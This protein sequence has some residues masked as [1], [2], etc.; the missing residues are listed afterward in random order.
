MIIFAVLSATTWININLIMMD[1]QLIEF[2]SR[3]ELLRL[4]VQRIVYIEADGNYSY[5]VTC[6]KLKGAV[7]MNLGQV[8]D[9][10]A[11]RLKERKSIF[12]R[13]GKK[14][15]VNLNYV[16]KINPLKKQL[17]LTDFNHFAF[18]L[19]ISREAL[20]ALKELMVKMKI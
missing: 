7:G 2:N 13:I 19:D 6:N 16:Y 20:K 5:I 11:N 1:R 8:E 4:D 3:D 12:A 17:V 10:L 15:I 18:Q 9:V 14:Y